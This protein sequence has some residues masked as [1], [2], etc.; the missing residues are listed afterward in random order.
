MSIECQIQNI[1]C[2][3]FQSE[4]RK[5]GIY[6]TFWKAHHLDLMPACGRLSGPLKNVIYFLGSLYMISVSQITLCFFSVYQKSDN[7]FFSAP[8]EDNFSTTLNRI[9]LSF[10]LKPY[11]QEFRMMLI[12]F[13][14]FFVL[15][16]DSIVFQSQKR[17]ETFCSSKPMPSLFQKS[18]LGFP[19]V[20]RSLSQVIDGISIKS[21]IGKK[22][23]YVFYLLV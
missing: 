14:R 7:C 23:D 18:T 12:A 16:K 21:A 5:K 4:Q 9:K 17:M 13:H 11:D 10:L 6:T 15:L 22:K 20:K 1:S 19:Q 3:Q 8:N 2:C